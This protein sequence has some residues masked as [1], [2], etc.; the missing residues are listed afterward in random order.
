MDETNR[1]ALYKLRQTWNEVFPN[2]VL[3]QIDVSVK[4]IDPAWPV[5]AN[6]PN[7]S[8]PPS[9]MSRSSPN[10]TSSK[11]IL[12]NQT[13]IITPSMTTILGQTQS[14]S[15]NQTSTHKT[16]SVITTSGQT[17]STSSLQTNKISQEVNKFYL[18]LVGVL[19]LFNIYHQYSDASF[20]KKNI[21]IA[22]YFKKMC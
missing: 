2:P 19:Y 21:F 7:S 6:N 14:I 17:S 10:Q 5:T 20:Y 22:N 11:S 12:L 16:A 4:R 13:N 9:A 15:S 1:K 18:I 8:Q 3:Y